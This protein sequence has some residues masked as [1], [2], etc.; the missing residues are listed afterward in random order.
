MQAEI[1]SVGDE[2]LLGMIADTNS[3][4]LSAGLANHGIAV[5][6]QT[7]VGDDLNAISDAVSAASARSELVIVNGGI[8]P[9]IDDVTRQAVAAAADVPLRMD[10]EWLDVIEA[11]FHSRK[12]EMPKSNQVQALIPETATRIFNPAGTAAGFYF[13]IDGAEVA[14]FP[15]VPPELKA[16]FEQEYLPGLLER[17]ATGRV[18]VTR[19]LK[20][21]GLPES[22]INEKLEH[23]MG[24]HKN[25]QV[26]LLAKGAVI[27]VKITA[28]ARDE[29][30][31]VN[32]ID[33]IKQEARGRLGD[34]VFGEDDDELQTAVARLLSERGLTL[35]TAESCTGGLIAERLTEISG[36]SKYFLGGAVTYS[37]EMKMDLLGVPEHLF[38][39]AG[40]VSSEV[41]QAMAEGIRRR[42]G[43]DYGIS[44]TGIAGPTGGTAQKPVGLVYIGIA[45]TK[46]TEVKELRLSGTRE[47]IRDRTAKQA[48][49]LVRLNVMGART[50]T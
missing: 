41:A 43:A 14:V 15:G 26:G 25:P 5:T 6:R 32:M 9:T 22:L 21:F 11:K 36:S 34:Y 13:M 2:I 40:A 17:A 30:T 3:A 27:S 23:L 1:V 49:N 16:M 45:D 44:V 50:P 37:N 48:L 18:I 10:D 19:S 8:G 38:D 33:E 20:C 46:G 39:E 31:A 47:H 7:T 29:P 4:Y 12:I 24:P 42:T 35:C 28:S